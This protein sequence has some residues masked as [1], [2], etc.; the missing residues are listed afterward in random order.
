MTALPPPQEVG[1]CPDCGAAQER[2]IIC[3]LP[4][5]LC[6]HCGLVEGL[7]AWA[8]TVP[9]EVPDEPSPIWI[10]EGPYL[11]GLLGWLL[12]RLLPDPGEDGRR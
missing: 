4:G 3:A 9:S 11:L 10:Y 7:A 12:A 1:L 2:C 5:R 6:S 8:P